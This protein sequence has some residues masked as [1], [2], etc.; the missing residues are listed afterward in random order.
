VRL[1]DEAK[2]NEEER[3]RAAKQKELDRVSEDIK[4]GN[5]EAADLEQSISLVGNAVNEAKSNLEL[6]AGRKKSA[7][8]DLELLALRSEAERLKAEGMSPLDSAH[9][10]ARE[11]VPRRKS[12]VP[13]VEPPEGNAPV[14]VV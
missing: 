2:K 4:K 9:A 10:K 11:A 12:F 13:S 14:V 6:L 1:L 8:Q 7:T 3:K 5:Q